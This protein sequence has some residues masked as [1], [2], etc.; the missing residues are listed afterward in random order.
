MFSVAYARAS[1]IAS[2][3]FL[4]SMEHNVIYQEQNTVLY[5]DTEAI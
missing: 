2:W 3:T 5:V 1:L 4:A